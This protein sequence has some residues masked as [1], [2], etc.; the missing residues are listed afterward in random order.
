M[1]I[2]L[3]DV[4]TQEGKTLQTEVPFGLDTIAFQ[5]G[6]FPIRK[7]SPVTL[8]IENVGDKVLEL[9]GRVDLTIAIPCDRCLEEAD[10]DFPL[11][12]RRKVD[13]KLSEEDRIKDLDES[14]YITGT[15]LDVDQL[16]CNE[17][18]M[19]WP[20]KVLCRD[21]CKGICSH[22]GKNLNHGPCGCEEEDLDPRMAAIRDIFSK[23]KEV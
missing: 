23:F 8:R 10:V 13:M 9:T 21:D 15:D 18:L 20:L 4:M 2:H 22:C 17:V 12:I 3:S 19:W 7:K 14:N 5:L 1:L 6:T 11:D 16:V